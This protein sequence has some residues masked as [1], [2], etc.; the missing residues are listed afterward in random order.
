[1]KRFLF[2]M[3][4]FC[5][6]ILSGFAQENNFSYTD[7]NGVT[8]GGYVGYDYDSQKTE[9][10][11]NTTSSNS[12]EEV[13]VP[14]EISYE[15][16]KYKVT[17]L[18]SVFSGNKIIE[19]V[20]IPKTVTSLSSTFQDCSALIEVVNTSQLKTVFYAFYN[21]SSLKS[22]DLSSCETL[23]WSSFVGCSQLE[24]VVLKACKRIEGRVFSNGN[25]TCQNL[26]SVGDISHC[27]SIGEYAFSDCSSLTSVDLSSCKTI[28]NY[29]FSGCS[30]LESI[31]SVKLLTNIPEYA[32]NGCSN[33]QNIDLSNCTSIGSS[34]FNGCSK[35]KHLNLNKC[36]YISSNAFSN[37]GLENIDLSATKTIEG[38]A[39]S[40]CS[41]LTKVT[42][43]KLVK[44]LP[45]GIFY[46][47][48]KLSSIDLS[49]IES[50]GASC[51]SG[52]A[53]ERVELPNLKSWDYGVFEDCK[54]LTSVTFPVTIDNIPTRAFWNCE[55]LSTI[56]L[57]HCSIIGGGA[58]YNCTSLTDIKL[59]N[60]KQTEWTT[61]YENYQ[62]CK[63]GSFMNCNN[64]TSVDL[65]SIQK[66]GDR[67]FYGCTSLKKI[68]L[69][70]TITNLGWECFDGVTIVTSM[71][72]VPPVIDKSED[73][74][75]SIPM[76]EFVLVNV[77]EASLDSY[78]SA[79]YWK[80]MAK[81]IFPIGT[82]FDY[83]VTTEAQPST[84][85]LLDKVGLKN[86]NSIV[87]LKVKG[88]INS[89]DVMVI[90]NKMDNLHYLDLSDANVVENSYEYYTG[91]STKNDTIGRNAFRELSKLVTISLP[92]SVKAIESGALYKCT[93]LKSVVLPENLQSI[94]YG[95]WS[96][97]AFADCYS[98]TDVKFKACNF[99]GSLAF[100]NCYALNHVTLP[101]DLKTIDQYAFANCS[102]L[103]SVDFPPLLESIGSY[104]FQSC[105]LDSISLPG[106]T[107]IDEYAFS[108]C[109]N[110]KEVKVPST[111]ESVGDK[112]FEGCS[113]L[114]DVFTYTIL[115]VKI[116]QNTFCT[117]ETA[118][119]HVPAQSYDNYFWDTEWSQFHAFEDF[120]EPYKYFY[121]RKE[122]I[123]SS[124]IEGIPNIDIY[125]GGGLI[126]KGNEIQN[127]GDIHI[128]GS[129][130][131]IANG[132]VDASK[133]HI[134]IDVNSNEWYFFSFPFDIKRS[135]I[136]APGQFIFRKYDGAT[137]ASQGSGGW[138]DLDAS[139]LWL[140]RGTG[141]IFQSSES[142]KLTLP[143]VKEKFG[144]L[145][146]ENVQ[147]ALGTYASNNEQNASWNFVGNP[148][149]SYFDMDDLGYNA[150]ITYWNGMSYE[151][152]RP[153]DDNYVFKPFQAFFVQKPQNVNE[154][155]FGAEFRLTQE[156]SQKRSSVNK[157]KRLAKGID[158]NRQMVNL[159]LSDGSHTDKTRIVFNEDKTQRYELDCD[160][161]KFE[162]S[163]AVPQLYTLEANNVQLAINER[164]LGSVN[165]GFEVQ[166]SGD[167]TIS[168]IRM[169]SPM[170]LKD[171]LTDATVDL[172]TSDYHFTSEAGTFNGRF[173]LMPN[174][175]T[176]GIADFAK[177]TGV[178]IIPTEGG[179][180]FSG[181][182]GKH[183]SIYSLNGIE[184]GSTQ[185][186]GTI[187]LGQ[188]IYVVKMDNTS[189]K[190]MV[191]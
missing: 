15:G 6:G 167:Y 59:F 171:N 38:Y 136:V 73:E 133:F 156:G 114:N 101:P 189:T 108:G 97:G 68:T 62:S 8:W 182:E 25:S 79:N 160:A 137:R 142:G 144:K 103:H 126:V 81:R 71:A 89:Y 132:N 179:I 157:A 155:E 32:F 107:R 49:T 163:T 23:G 36:A 123:L 117:Y 72:T 1:M 48:H 57:S 154:M 122:F 125:S 52:T 55:N 183:V 86:A 184:I 34:A 106:L 7:D 75:S 17:K 119:L 46:G 161:A 58:L 98:L 63:V 112:A 44:L 14:D 12:E 105:A 80:D 110:L 53:I 128:N 120:N 149:T 186:S 131:I 168:A 140:H 172:S 170:L 147:E 40:G 158:V 175:S 87:S 185:S 96:S 146:A 124:R 135:D 94:E 4:L 143:V 9:A 70:S 19:K 78:K 92:N 100:S 69:P 33:L 91:C 74:T 176:T 64:L 5:M 88:S 130:T 99:I 111:L 93:K 141:Y 85:D 21:C 165:L 84:S 121:L 45:A 10:S 139:D 129:G 27:E 2:L 150:P 16:E 178:S 166:K 18:G 66:L 104:A 42:G 151:A 76:G 188:G 95:D 60:V 134:D 116:N 51:M 152:V 77:P 138:K 28:G 118:T 177:N 3:V 190:V 191:K 13:V 173:T 187:N 39:F 54:K 43:L 67:A 41:C 56:D 82:K 26:K 50:L 83:D 11:I 30:A 65:G 180:N 181:V 169:D 174:K 35:I 29:S 153:G 162:S 148:H 102:S 31:G 109:G 145:E 164:P 115:P 47:C 159:T 90:R 127:A 20:T 24:N 61:S 113:N 22:V 37:C